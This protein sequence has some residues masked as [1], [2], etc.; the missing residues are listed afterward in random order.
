MANIFYLE[1]DENLSLVVKDTL[2]S[3]GHKVYHYKRG[4]VALA[5]FKNLDPDL[6]L[7]D[8]ML[9]GIDGFTLARTIRLVNKTIPI[10][11]IS[12]K[13]QIEDKLE[14][15]NLGGD[16]YI[17]KPFSIEELLLKVKI[18]FNRKYTQAGELQK[19]VDS[20]S[21]S[22]FEFDP[23]NQ[24]L[25][26]DDGTEVDLTLR[27]SELLNFFLSHKNQ[28]LKREEILLAL[29][30]QDDYFLGRSLDV[31]I[32]R[33]RKHLKKDPGVLIET[34]PRVGFRMRF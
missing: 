32:S 22:R 5:E 17:F 14:G 18:F 31:F 29:W 25:K 8:V 34:I 6:C 7:L 23:L 10:I 21:F 28:L 26:H 19:R 11:F 9:P 16:D 2:E 12:A 13:V 27:E 20:I 4:D 33:L 24:K 1:D 30:G 15:L 3:A